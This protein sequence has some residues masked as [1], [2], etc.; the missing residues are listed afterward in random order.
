MPENAPPVQFTSVARGY[1]KA[2]IPT[3]LGVLLILQLTNGHWLLAALSVLPAVLLVA[4]GIGLLLW[5]GDVR[6]PQYLTLGAGLA[7]LPGVAALVLQLPVLGAVLILAAAL[8]WWVAGTISLASFPRVSGAPAPRHDWASAARIGTDQALLAWFKTIIRPPQNSARVQV[9]DELQQW[10]DCWMADNPP[11][12]LD[13]HPTPPALPRVEGMERSLFGLRY[14]HIRW[15][16]EFPLDEDWPGLQRWGQHMRNHRAHAW[17]LEHPGKPRPWLLTIHG[18]RMGTPGLDFR[19]FEPGLLH[20]RLGLNIASVV[21]PL[22]GP[23][24][25][26]RVSGGH[27]LDGDFSTFVH[28]ERQA[29]WDIR[30][31]LSWLRLNRHAPAIGVYGLS[32]GGYN[33]ALLAG[34][35]EDLACVIA[36]IPVFDMA[37]T[38]WRHIPLA[39]RRSLEADGVS[40]DLLRMAYAPVSPGM[41]AA[42]LPPSRLGIF[43]GTMDSL[44]WPD[45]PLQL[46][47]HWQVPT[48][49]WFPGAHLTFAGTSAQRQC[50]INTLAAGGLIDAQRQPIRS[51]DLP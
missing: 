34:L 28:A 23:R 26:G 32:L 14:K 8:S 47:Q 1:P 41:F 2:I 37:Q 25:T 20:K 40:E 3:L 27:Y 9:L 15:L 21:L 42:Q 7:V 46:A 11:A 33:A 35:D 48:P 29:Q 45:Q 38:Q 6:L 51:A 24:K 36:G 49:Y 30:R 22:H 17:L 31:L 4:S 13:C 16:S 10:R 44:V 50:L 18:Y 12:L 19:A 39:L 5:P 43:A